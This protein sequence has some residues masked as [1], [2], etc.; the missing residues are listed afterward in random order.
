VGGASIHASRLGAGFDSTSS[1]ILCCESDCSGAGCCGTEP[2]GGGR[3]GP[4]SSSSES[5]SELLLLSLWLSVL[6][7]GGGRDGPITLRRLSEALSVSSVV[8]PV[9]A[10]WS[11]FR[12]EGLSMV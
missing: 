2:D 12:F 10:G 9:V 1:D 5:E 11:S 3:L 6:E 7:V 8:V 4:K